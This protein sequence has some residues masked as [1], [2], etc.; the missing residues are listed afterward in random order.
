MSSLQKSAVA[1]LSLFSIRMLFNFI[2]QS[3]TICMFGNN[4]LVLTSLPFLIVGDFTVGTDMRTTQRKSFIRC[5]TFICLAVALQ[6]RKSL[7]E[8]QCMDMKGHIFPSI[9]GIW[10][11]ARHAFFLALSM[12]FVLICL[13]SLYQIKKCSK[14]KGK[15]GLKTV[16][17]G[18]VKNNITVKL[19]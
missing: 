3:F 12:G 18:A 10:L 6:D 16:M 17:W 14:S 15:E 13:F 19:G 4:L 1:S 2:F 9:G 5:F 8:T 7:A 11:L